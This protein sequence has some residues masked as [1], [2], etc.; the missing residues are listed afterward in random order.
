M[1]T[2]LYYAALENGFT[3][4]TAFISE[5]TT[6]PLAEGKTY[7]PH[8]YNDIYGDKAIS[9][10]TAIAYSDNIYA[11][12]THLFLGTDALIQVAK[13][14]GI[15][16]PLDEVPSL[17]L[18]T[19][20]INIIEM[21]EGYS[22]FANLGYKVSGHLINKVVDGKGNIIYENKDNKELVLNP[23]LVYILNNMLTAPYDSHYIDYNY[24][25]A[26]S[27]SNK[28]NHTYALKSGTTSV[29][30]WDIGFN[31]DVLCAVWVGYDEGQELVKSDYKY[32]QNIWYQTVEYYEKDLSNEDVWY[33]TPSNV[34]GVLVE[35]I[36]G[37][38]ATDQDQN[39]KIMYFLKGTEPKGDEPV[40][41]EIEKK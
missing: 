27:L 6:F 14:V 9:M 34:V 8:N 33:E 23:S 12:K 30:N 39:A 18:G 26:I 24:P 40:F 16:E 11:V 19:S 20:E 28:L 31:K 35:P 3:S 10:A 1:K 37:K 36:S 2:F 22:A 38:P 29:D 25:T 41:D 32:A 4:S 17:P 21:A 15:D 5:R 7:S 13:R